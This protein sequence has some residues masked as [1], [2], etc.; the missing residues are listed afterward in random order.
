MGTS[1]AVNVAGYQILKMGVVDQA[2]TLLQ[3][4]VRDYPESADSR[5]GLGRALRTDGRLKEARVEFERTL[6]IDREHDRAKTAL[7]EMDRTNR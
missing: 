7:E 1:D 3:Q 6:L 4:N 5:F 2:I